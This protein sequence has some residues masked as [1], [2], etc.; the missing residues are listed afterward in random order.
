MMMSA[1][2][3]LITFGFVAWKQAFGQSASG[4]SSS[5]SC[6]INSGVCSQDGSSNSHSISLSYTSSTGMFSG[7]ITTN[8][9]MN[10]KYGYINGTDQMHGKYF[11][12]PDCISQT[13][14]APDYKTVPAAINLRGRV[15]LTLSGGVNIFSP[16][17][18]GFTQGQVCDSGSCS[19]GIDVSTCEKKMLKQC[20]NESFTWALMPDDCG[21]HSSPYH[22]HVKIA[23]DYD[24]TSSS[25][26]SKLIGVA[27]DGR[28]IYGKWEGSGN[29]PSDLDACNGHYG[30]VP[31]FTDSSSGVSFA[32]ASN[33]YHY[34]VSD[35]PPFTL[36]CFG[37]VSSLDA[38][39]S[40]YSTCGSGYSC[41]DTTSGTIEYDTDCPCYQQAGQTY[42]QDY[43]ST[44]TPG[45][46]FDGPPLVMRV[47]VWI[48]AV[49][50]I[51]GCC[52]GG[53]RLYKKHCAGGGKV[54][55]DK[56]EEKKLERYS[57]DE[58]SVELEHTTKP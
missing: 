24:T 51:V 15:G 19:S 9:C 33:V 31:A 5:S 27:L 34:H 26:H 37:P 10:H 35:G 41:V 21:G 20:A 38:C 42:N 49:G 13:I 2:L 6:S 48:V 53:R 58:H 29:L 47:L 3:L 17:E 23:C 54:V 16:F 18:D 55:F 52:V 50:T 11:H 39:K 57:Q 25:S 36:G 28:G 22:L 4:E 1:R 56:L 40:L 45:S 12:S 7:S 43:N 8:Q 46:D 44:C 32:A 14:P 30:D